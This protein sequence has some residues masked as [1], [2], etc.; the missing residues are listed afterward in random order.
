MCLHMSK[1]AD[2]LSHQSPDEKEENLINLMHSVAELLEKEGIR[3]M[4]HLKS[5]G[6]YEPRLE[7]INT[8][9]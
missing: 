8:Q 7:H 2:F 1:L 9:L 5:D 6:S 3:I 4:V